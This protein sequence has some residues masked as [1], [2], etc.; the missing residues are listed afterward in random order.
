MIIYIPIHERGKWT[1]Q[2]LDTTHCIYYHGIH[3]TIKSYGYIYNGENIF[4]TY[5]SAREHISDFTKPGDV[6]P[7][8]IMDWGKNYA[9]R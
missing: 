6:K 5:E 7:E 8:N 2:Q 4:S 9:W 1:V 3:P